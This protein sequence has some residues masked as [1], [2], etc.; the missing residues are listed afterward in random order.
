M[1]KRG[2]L[3]FN[4]NSGSFRSQDKKMKEIML[5]YLSQQHLPVR[6]MRLKSMT[7][8]KRSRKR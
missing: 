4:M 2:E 5:K 7:N 1:I 8:E 6:L 3:R